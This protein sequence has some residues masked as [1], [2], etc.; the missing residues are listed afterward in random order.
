MRVGLIINPIAGMGGPVGLKGTDGGAHI[1][2]AEL[3]AAR[4]SHLIA[5]RALSGMRNDI[6]FVSV[7]NMGSETLNDLGI[8]HITIATAPAETGAD[9]TRNAAKLMARDCNLILFCG[10][11]G[12]ARDVLDAVGDTVPVLGIPAGVKMYSSVFAAVPESVPEI[13]NAFLNGTAKLTQREVMDINEEDHRKGILSAKLYGHMTV[14]YVPALVQSC[15][16]VYEGGDEEDEAD[17]VAE[18]MVTAM[19]DDTLYIIGPGNTA[20]RIMERLGFTHTLLGVDAVLG[21]R[22]IGR[23]LNEEELISVLGR[24]EKRALILGII[25]KQGFFLGRGNREITPKVIR[26]IGT[27][28]IIL[29]S[30]ISK[31]NDLDELRVDTGDP[32]LDRELKGYRKVIFRHARER[33]MRVV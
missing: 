16:G 21:G 22:M 2:A 8:S 15:K 10:G 11:D 3:G 5:A 33:M 27:D 17:E 12:T 1:A 4:T 9:D 14:P 23:D 25:G 30:G 6:V 28:N 24:H 26:M 31:L 7:G 32:E 19:S 29:V 13:V 20:G 18:Y